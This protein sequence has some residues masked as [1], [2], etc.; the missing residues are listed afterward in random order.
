MDNLLD[1]DA[2]RVDGVRI[3]AAVWHQMLDLSHSQPGGRCHDGIEIAGRLSIDK[4]AFLIALEGMHQSDIGKQT[5]FH[6]VV[7]FPEAP[8]PSLQRSVCRHRFS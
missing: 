7:V 3:D 8:G 4:V 1:E 2:R 6:N 5:G